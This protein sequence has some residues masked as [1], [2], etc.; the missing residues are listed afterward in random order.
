MITALWIF[1]LLKGVDWEKY[2]SALCERLIS[3]VAR[4][5]YGVYLTHHFI[6]R[7]V[8]PYFARREYNISVIQ[9]GLC[10]G[11]SLFLTG[12]Y[13]LMIIGINYIVNLILKRL[14]NY[15]KELKRK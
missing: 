15:Y 5:S 13:T 12:T 8:V 11:T 7:R 10:L 14:L 1:V 3:S 4:Y 6:I 9:M 2:V